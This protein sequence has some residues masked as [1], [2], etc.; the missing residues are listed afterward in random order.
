MTW[1]SR[2]L[3]EKQK[4]RVQIADQQLFLLKQAQQNNREEIK[5]NFKRFTLSKKG[6][7]TFTA[8]GALYELLQQNETEQS[9]MPLI[10]SMQRWWVL[11][12]KL[13]LF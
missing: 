4:R 6:L 8:S 1:L 9:Q 5:A 12:E 11:A 13:Q 3:V 7:L 10:S 2:R